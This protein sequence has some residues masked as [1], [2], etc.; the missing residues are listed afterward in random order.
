[1]LVQ[2]LLSTDIGD[3]AECHA[4]KLLE[5][6]LLQFKGNIDHVSNLFSVTRAAS[7][8]RSRSEVK[9]HCH[10][11]RGRIIRTVL[12]SVQQLCTVNDTHTTHMSSS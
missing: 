7:L 6:I 5:V 11:I 2:V 3:D 1:M 4:A 8:S 9:V 10:R 12:C